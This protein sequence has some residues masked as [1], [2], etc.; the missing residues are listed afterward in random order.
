AGQHGTIGDRRCKDA[1]GTPTSIASRPCLH[2]WTISR[3]QTRVNSRERRS[4]RTT[5]QFWSYSGLAIVTR[6]SSDSVR[7]NGHWVRKPTAQT[8]GLNRNRQPLL[9]ALFKGAA[10]TVIHHLPKHPLHQDFQRMVSEAG[11]KP[12]LAKL[13]LA[14]RIAAATLAIWKHQEDYD[15]SKQRR[16]PLSQ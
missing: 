6:S 9:K 5:R 3:E 7:E 14:R 10:T 15:P 12:N 13:T 1:G 8:R 16:A 4:F 2:G 11:V